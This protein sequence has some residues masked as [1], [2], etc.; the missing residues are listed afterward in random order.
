MLFFNHKYRYWFALAL[1]VYTYLSTLFCN[2]YSYFGM[3]V[4]WYTAL[5]SIVVITVGTWEAGR[6]LYP[7]FHKLPQKEDLI[8]RNLLVY[9]MAA[10]VASGLFTVAVVFAFDRLF[11]HA[12][13]DLYNPLKLTLTYALLINLLFHLLHAVAYYMERYKNKQLEA[14]E[15]LRMHTQAE[16]QSIKSQVNPH[17]LFNNLN[18]LSAL[19]LKQSQDANHFIEAFSNVYQY[20]LRNQE[21]ELIDLQQELD[22][23]EPYI[24]L[25]QHRFPNSIQLNIQIAAEAKQLQVVPVALQMLV[26]NAIKHNIVSPQQPLQIHITSSDKKQLTVANN[27]QP[28]RNKAA[29]GNV[30]LVNIDQRYAITTGKHIAVKNDGQQFSVSIPLIQ[31]H[32]YAGSY[33]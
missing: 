30:G 2:V 23:L 29:S 20:I 11:H 21:K 4:Q 7:L 13:I 16:L 8:I 15:L 6:L 28:K 31:V 5:G 27:L 3:D 12:P 22:F 24:Y 26:E 18:V 19:V 32:T 17:F 33:H 10:G 14:E 1:A 25:L 9:W